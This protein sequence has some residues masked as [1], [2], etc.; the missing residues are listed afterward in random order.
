MNKQRFLDILSKDLERINVDE[1]DDII[2]QYNEH[3]LRKMADGLSEEEIV[4]KLGKPEDVAM[5]YESNTDTTTGKQGNNILL[6]IGIGFADIWIVSFF[7]IIFVW[8]LV[9]VVLTIAFVSLGICLVVAP[10]FITGTAVIPYIPYLPGAITGIASIALGVISAVL[11]INCYMLAVKLGTAWLRWQ[12]NVLSGKRNIPYSV[13]PLFKNNFKYKL[14]K[15]II[16]SLAVFGVLFV[17]GFISMVLCSGRFEFW[18]AWRWF[19][20]AV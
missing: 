14:R 16:V 3:F 10:G 15:V 8:D 1:I 11:T 17:I 5:Q 9:L 12:K 18:H 7:A 4:S 6:T 13:F 2:E 20:Y 19:N